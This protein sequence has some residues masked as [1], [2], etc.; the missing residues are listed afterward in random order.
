MNLA[1][2]QFRKEFHWLW[3]RWVLLL[4]ALGCDL[5]YNMEWIF[6]MK[7]GDVM[8][9]SE[10]AASVLW[11]LGWWVMLSTAPEDNAQGFA[12]T[13]PLPRWSY[14]LARL[15]VW[16]LLVVLPFV[17][18]AG[19]YLALMHRPWGDIGTGMAEEALA[20]SA[21]TL[22]VLPAGALFRGWER[23]L[24]LVVFAALWGAEYGRNLLGYLFKLI[25][26]DPYLTFP[27]YEPMRFVQAGWLVG[28]LM[29]V[30]LLWH[31]RRPLSLTQ[32]LSAL[33]VLALVAYGL[34]ASPL[35]HSWFEAPKNL[36]LARELGEGR[37]AVVVPVDFKMAIVESEKNGP[38]MNI[39]TCAA[40]DGIR[41]GI[42]PIW[43]NVAT[44]ITQN[45]RELPQLTTK[46]M[47]GHVNPQSLSFSLFYSPL[48]GDLAA[49][50]PADLLCAD[51]NVTHHRLRPLQLL[52]PNDL[53]TP[54]DMDM[55][56]AANWVRLRD[57]GQA[58]LKAGACIRTP[59]A[60]LE[61][62]A[63]EV[64]RDGRGRLMPGVMTV[65]VRQC[66]RTLSANHAWWPIGPKIIVLAAGKRLTWERNMQSSSDWRSLRLGWV[67][68]VVN[69]TFQDVLTAGTGVTEANLAEQLQ[70][71]WIKPDYLGT[72]YHPTEVKG[73]SLSE[74]LQ[75]TDTW[76]WTDAAIRQ[77]ANPREALLRH[78]RRLPRPDPAAPR[79]EVERYVANVCSAMRAYDNR[80][81]LNAFSE[82]LWP[83]N[84][85]ELGELLAPFIVK[86]P[87]LI[88]K[89]QAPEAFVVMGAALVKA[90][91]P[92]FQQEADAEQ[93]SY[94]CTV[95]MSGQPGVL[96]SLVSKPWVPIKMGAATAESDRLR[97]DRAVMEMLRSGSDEALRPLISQEP[98]PLEKIWEEFPGAVN[99]VTLRLL[100]RDA[101][102]RDRA[103]AETRRQYALLARSVR[104]ED[105]EKLE[106]IAA[107]AVLG[108]A[109]ALDW[110]L[111]VAGTRP[112]DRQGWMNEYLRNVH[113]TV[114]GR[115]LAAR[116]VSAFIVNC[117]GWTPADF[118]YDAEKMHWELRESEAA[119]FKK[120]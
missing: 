106:V 44:R 3:P 55:Q 89:L 91:I 9:V 8:G 28:P 115:E 71:Q 49:P 76:P 88:A 34:A 50:A 118:R 96:Q 32:R 80:G 43:S 111:R 35:M 5:A 29:V 78:V 119:N 18:E 6:P 10:V 4:A 72:T 99:G 62:M 101:H 12:M 109:N 110:L 54:V 21:M 52:K 100:V 108:E 7:P 95:A 11:L 83:G 85:R 23:Y 51:A 90:G 41:R 113:R 64:N 116:E 98:R 59:E 1:L 58:P 65:T 120:P 77:E 37:E 107:M 19:V 56:L 102:Y 42:I 75:K 70:I 117:R 84:D 16:A 97:L 17:I 26:L 53:N 39:G 104:L 82:P 27:F 61:V 60:E 63:V 25:D 2:H 67:H 73:M 81:E 114:F 66:M 79:A 86:H 92:G 57:L 30:L 13:R 105:R 69:F 36:A 40:L 47:E 20:A 46:Y 74:H 14:W 68:S 87:D 48:A 15:L 31:M 94:Q 45:G 22:W 33:G 93:P 38:L 103:I 112:E 24:A